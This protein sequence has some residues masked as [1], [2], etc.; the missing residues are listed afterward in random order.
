MEYRD[1]GKTGLK[2]SIIGFGGIVVMNETQDYADRAVGKAIDRGVN[3]FDVAPSYNDAELR[4]GPALK[5]KRDNIIL[6]CKTNERCK[7]GA[8]DQ[9]QKSLKRLQTDRF[10]IFQ[11]HGVNT[12][13][14]LDAIFGPDGAMEAVADARDKGLTR[15]IGIT[16][17][18]PDIA[19]EAMRRFDFD[20][21]LFPVNFIY[22]NKC[23]ACREVIEEA[24]KRG[25][26]RAAMKSMAL[27]PWGECEDHKWNKTWYCPNDNPELVELAVRF[28]LS[29]DINVL[30]PPG[31]LELWE[32]AISVAE[33][34]TPLDAAE[35][36][37]LRELSSDYDLIF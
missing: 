2:T 5:G 28:T 14:E 4:L 11:F 26:G 32:M 10:D 8:E 24:S 20:S 18:T 23:D 6:A 15:F 29:R 3:Y 16:V 27:R 22:W 34:Y 30:V 19:A 37:R 12:I 13:E 7:A 21:F 35:E 17:H 1:F 33:K 31:H 25:M 36:A 9:L